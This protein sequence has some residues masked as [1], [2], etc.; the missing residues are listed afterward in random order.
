MISRLGAIQLTLNLIAAL[1]ETLRTDNAFANT[2][3]SSDILDPHPNANDKYP[4]AM[5]ARRRIAFDFAPVV[6]GRNQITAS[7]AHT[8][9]VPSPAFR[10]SPCPYK[11]QTEPA[12][13]SRW[14]SSLDRQAP[15][16]ELQSTAVSRAG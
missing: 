4:V 12:R 1:A 14:R 5:N 10:Q 3:H 11:S 7:L 16:P 9:R 8:I 15:T 13:Q 2:A 6:V